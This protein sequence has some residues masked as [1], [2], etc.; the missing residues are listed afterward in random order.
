AWF[1]RLSRTKDG[2]TKLYG[3]SGWLER[4]GSWELPLGTTAREILFERAGGL[5]DGRKLRGFLPGGAST[6]FLLE[7]HL[8]LPLD[9]AALQG[10]GSRLGT[11]TIIALDDRTCP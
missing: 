3:A 4:P 10:V 5:S 9:F 6:A 7:E 2:G 8:D 1:H 11:G